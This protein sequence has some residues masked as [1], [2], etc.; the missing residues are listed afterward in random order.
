MTIVQLLAFETVYVCGFTVLV[1]SIIWLKSY[2]PLC[3]R[4][5]VCCG[6]LC[7]VCMPVLSLQTSLLVYIQFGTLFLS[8]TDRSTRT[9]PVDDMMGLQSG[10]DFKGSGFGTETADLTTVSS[11]F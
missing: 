3:V 10:N 11:V 8:G 9:P 5:V 2:L 1:K 6:C 7:G 4:L